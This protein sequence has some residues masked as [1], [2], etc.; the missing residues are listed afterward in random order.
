M[1]IGQQTRTRYE[2]LQAQLR[3]MGR[4]AVAYSGGVDSTFL[5]AV[6]HEALGDELLALTLAATMVP[7]RDLERTRAFCAERGIEQVV[8]DVDALQIA[9]FAENPPDR[10]YHC[11]RELFSRMTR[12]AERR[13]FPTLVDGSNKDDEGD[14]RP[15][16]RALA[17]LHIGSPLRDAGLTKAEIRALSQELGLPTW[18]MPSAA[19][20]A[21]RVPYGEP[22]THEKL[23]R[24]EA[25]EDC[26]RSLGIVQLRVRVHGQDGRL[27]RIEVPAEDIAR[28]ADEPIRTQLVEQLQALG[29]AY[30]SLDLKG[31]RSGA[32][33]EVL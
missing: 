9:H 5:L 2:E 8:V 27:A 12:E 32:M 10:C 23:A 7:A 25:A 31:F 15:G 14:Y 24:I 29:F 19:C 4:V 30:V 6:A 21:S 16:M 13:G 17:E 18:S 11:K 26:L 20:L 33:N 1:G 3:G 28:I 22:I